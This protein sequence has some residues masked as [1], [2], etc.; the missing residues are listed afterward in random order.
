MT[1]DDPLELTLEINE[2][3]DCPFGSTMLL[4]VEMS[5]NSGYIHRAIVDEIT[6]NADGKLQDDNIP[7]WHGASGSIYDR[8]G[9]LIW[10]SD[11]SEER[12]SY[13][14]K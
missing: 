9:T 3:F 12:Y 7:R 4:M 13:L 8:E 10:G 14:Y 2:S 1:N 6:V 5:D 11:W